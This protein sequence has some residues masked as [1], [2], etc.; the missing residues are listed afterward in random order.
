M[1]LLLF[2]CASEKPKT[3]APKPEPT[4]AVYKVLFTTTK[5]DFTVEVTRAWAPNGADRFWELVRENFFDDSAFYRVMK[6]YVAQFG[7]HRDPRVNELWRLN[8]T[9]D[10]Q[11]KQSNKKGAIAFAHNGPN[12]RTT[13]VFVN[14][15]DNSGRLDGQS[16]VPFGKV[17]SG[18][19]VVEKL[20]AGYGDS[21]PRGYGPDASKL[22]NQ[23]SAYLNS[24]PRL[25]FIKTA[26]VLKD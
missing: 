12:T 23:G 15:A 25:D 1:S 16:F 5:G 8:R 20:Y 18:M 6:G 19:D 22:E 13:Q 2:G 4:P 14:L 21:S 24:F 10:D 11:R 7:I 9:F 17:V 3:E 26:R